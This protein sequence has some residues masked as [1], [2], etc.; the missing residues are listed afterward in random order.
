MLYVLRDIQTYTID[1]LV[2]KVREPDHL[3]FRKDSTWFCGKQKEGPQHSV[4]M[5]KDN[6][7]LICRQC[8]AVYDFL[9]RSHRLRGRS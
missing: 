5:T 2:G 3:G 4:D 9:D 6:R 8:L 7:E 1:E